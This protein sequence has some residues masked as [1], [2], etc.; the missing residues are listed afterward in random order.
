M[1]KLYRRIPYLLTIVILATIAVQLYSG[2]IDFQKNSSNFKREMQQS[3]DVALD[4]YFIKVSEQKNITLIVSKDS[5]E[6]LSNLSMEKKV[7]EAISMKGAPNNRSEEHT[8]EL[9][10][11]PHLVC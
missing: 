4:N 1:K 3:L 6:K 10:S 7:M 2:Y 8:S 11:R 9:Q 5:L